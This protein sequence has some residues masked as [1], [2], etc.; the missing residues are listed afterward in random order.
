[1]PRIRT[2]QFEGNMVLGVWKIT[3]SV[4]D[5]LLLKSLNA[6]EDSEFKKISNTNRKRQW[7]STR[8][9]LNE[10]CG[11]NQIIHHTESGVPFIESSKL[12]ISISHTTNYVAVMLSEKFELGIDIEAINPRA[13]KVKHKFLSEEE[14]SA[15]LNGKNELEKI[16]T[17]WSAK[18][19]LFKLYVK[20]NL[21][22]RE[23]LK[24]SPFEFLP[25]GKIEAS[26]HCN[27]YKSDFELVYDQIEDH[28][29]VYGM[30]KI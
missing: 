14:L 11:S 16:C 4:D 13:L 24:L 18:E 10:L 2:N 28:I 15:L 26:I 20:G 8:V 1:M 3:E 12:K 5:L 9:L 23:H 19:S 25:P 29:L 22:F 17:A 6:F 27:N 30:N 21:D 7:L